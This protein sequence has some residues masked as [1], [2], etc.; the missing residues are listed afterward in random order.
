V[1]G[2]D[3]DRI[4][5]PFFRASTVTQSSGAGL[6]L[7]IVRQIA[8]AHGGTVEYAPREGGGSRFVVT[9]PHSTLVGADGT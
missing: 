9:L 8:R 2:A 3:R 5:E 6:G 7:S 1:S 4:F